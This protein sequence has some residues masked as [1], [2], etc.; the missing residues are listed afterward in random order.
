MAKI[1]LF[2]QGVNG[3]YVW[4]LLD[5]DGVT[6]AT[7]PNTYSVKSQVRSSESS[8]STLLAELH[9]SVV[10]GNSVMVDWTDTESRTWT[11][12]TGYMDVILRDASD[13]GVKIVWKGK[14][15]LS[16]AVTAV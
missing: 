14:A 6:P 4:P 15:S 1:L 10:N 11:W 12:D 3:G 16:K 9:G 13:F 5:S 2:T 8:S 7:I